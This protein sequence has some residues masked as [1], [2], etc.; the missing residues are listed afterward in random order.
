MAAGVDGFDLAALLAPIAG[1]IPGGVDPREDSS[2]QSL[3]Y[4]LRDARAEARATE[5]QADSGEVSEAAALPQWEAVTRLATDL[6]LRRAKDLEVA[7]WCTE[8]LLRCQGLAGLAVG[9]RLMLGLVETYWD[10]LHPVPDEEDGVARRTAPVAGLNGEGVDGTLIQPLRKLILF[11]RPDGGGLA[12]WQYQQSAE[13]AGVADAGRR[14]QRLEAGVLPFDTVET[15]ARLSAAR[16]GMLRRLAADAGQSWNDM[17]AALEARAG[18]AS[19]P[20]SRVRDLLADLLKVADRY[21]PPV[22]PEIGGEVATVT[23]PDQPL[24]HLRENQGSIATR[25]DALRA[26]DAIAQYFRQTEPHSPLSYTLQ[27]AIRR[28]RLSWPELLEE[29]VPD[30]R[31]RAAILS[32]LG[33]RP[34]APPE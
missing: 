26:L 34:P 3:Y 16:F 9:S 11:E 7:A 30:L 1:D 32:S 8:A 4:R 17:A 22:E 13:L 33:I 20:T 6:L 31:G 21:A 25:D 23:G 2:P 15:E 18:R 19:P 24:V 14:K 5:R 12:F 29:I 27:E 10:G 28:A